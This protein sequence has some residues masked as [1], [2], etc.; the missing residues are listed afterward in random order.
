ML[1]LAPDRNWPQFIVRPEPCTAACAAATLLDQETVQT[2]PSAISAAWAHIDS[3][4][5]KAEERGLK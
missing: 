1:L 3:H 5:N 2:T 4:Q